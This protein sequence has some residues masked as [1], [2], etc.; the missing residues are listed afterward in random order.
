MAKKI[1]FTLKVTAND[2]Y[3][4]NN[5]F[6]CKVVLDFAPPFKA[7][8]SSQWLGFHANKV[9]DLL[10]FISDRVI[11]KVVE[12]VYYDRDVATYDS[13]KAKYKPINGLKLPGNYGDAMVIY[14]QRRRR[15]KPKSA[16]HLNYKERRSKNA[17]DDN[18]NCIE[19]IVNNFLKDPN[20]PIWSKEAN[21]TRVTFQQQSPPSLTVETRTAVNGDKKPK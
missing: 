20:R 17:K 4:E 9:R 5:A 7:V 11:K 12:G 14:D 3:P 19:C 1:N 8:S 21:V 15:K 10:N 18:E 6:K 16:A 13:A 2:I